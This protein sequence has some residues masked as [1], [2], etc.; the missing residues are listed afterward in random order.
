MWNLF[1]LIVQAIWTRGKAYMRMKI[2]MDQIFETKD[3]A[4][5][6]EDSKHS[7]WALEWDK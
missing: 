3:K 4:L 7:R 5:T 1:E 2:K 6:R